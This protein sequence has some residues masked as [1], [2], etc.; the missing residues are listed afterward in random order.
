MHGFLMSLIPWGTEVILWAQSF[1]N[2]FLDRLFTAATFLGEKEFY[3]AF[4]PLIYWCFHKRTG[5]R[6]AY[7]FLLSTYLNLFVKDLFGIP[8]PDDPRI[9]LLRHETT[10]SF[11]SGHAQG[12]VV[13]WGYL[14][15]QWRNRVLWAIAIVLIL[16]NSVSRV[17]L[18]VHFPQDLVG[19]IAIGVL[20]L[21]GFNWIT[22]QW[23]GALAKLPLAAK[24]GLALLFPA[25]L[26]VVHP[27]QDT[28]IT[29]GALSGMGLGFLLEDKFVRFSTNG[30]WRRRMLRFCIGL[31]LIG[32]VYVGLEAVFP[33]QVALPLALA[34]RAVRYG[35]VGLV[36]TFLV[37]WVFVRIALADGNSDDT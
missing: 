30:S 33:T 27:T 4:L 36:G 6:L 3:L 24:A 16:L 25:A 26:L 14:A 29:M 18:G 5:V 35:L 7:V 8:R 11:P 19:G 28:A 15:A 2:P 17:Y 13:T 12:A 31:V 21:L 34:L 37:P 20:Y 10:P 1:G 9:R 32:I 22:G 23:S